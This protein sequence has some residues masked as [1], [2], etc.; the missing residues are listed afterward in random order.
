MKKFIA[1]W[2]VEPELILFKKSLRVTQIEK[3]YYT[4]TLKQ[5]F[6]LA[7]KDKHKCFYL[8]GVRPA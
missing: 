7:K 8:A 2:L 3:E 6:T 1:I 5:A 4:K